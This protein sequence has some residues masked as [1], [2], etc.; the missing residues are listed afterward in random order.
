M[1]KDGLVDTYDSNDDTTGSKV[2]TM[3]EFV[4]DDDVWVFIDDKLVLDLGGDHKD[5]F[6]LIDKLMPIQR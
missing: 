4:G 6:G 5:T 1:N 3:F 2:H